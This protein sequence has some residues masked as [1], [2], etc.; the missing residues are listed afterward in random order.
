MLK[1]SILKYPEYGIY[2][3]D[4]IS[5]TETKLHANIEESVTFGLMLTIRWLSAGASIEKAKPLFLVTFKIISSYIFLEKF[6]V[7]H[8]FALKI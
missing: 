1:Y 5:E 2:G 8:K 3:L 6:I 4:T 7:I